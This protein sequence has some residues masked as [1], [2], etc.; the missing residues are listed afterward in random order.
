M[1]RVKLHVHESGSVS[2]KNHCWQL[3]LNVSLRLRA[4]TWLWFWFPQHPHLWHT[5]SV[6]SFLRECCPQKPFLSPPLGNGCLSYNQVFPS[7]SFSLS[8][9]AAPDLVTVNDSPV[10]RKLEDGPPRSPWCPATSF[11]SSLLIYE[12]FPEA[13]HEF[14]NVPGNLKLK[15]PSKFMSV[16]LSMGR[17]V[18]KRGTLVCPARCTYHYLCVGCSCWPR[19][20]SQTSVGSWTAEANLA[21]HI[22]IFHLI[23]Q[24]P[25]KKVCFIN[26]LKQ[27]FEYSQNVFFLGQSN[28]KSS[29]LLMKKSVLRTALS[30]FRPVGDSVNS[31]S[32]FSCVL[33]K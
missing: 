33:V 1:E 9:T 32:F 21:F 16:L 28:F 12:T 31:Y 29:L 13:Q 14:Q 15:R 22:C 19:V 26:V 10:E 11:T 17:V 23:Y 20:G 4:R 25:W 5:H 2:V 7:F 18:T 8:F 27:Q 30:F 6:A 24:C 3:L